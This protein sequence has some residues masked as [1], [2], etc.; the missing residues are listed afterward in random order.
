MKSLTNHWKNGF[1]WRKQEAELNMLPQFKT[2]IEVDGFGILDMHFV[3][4][5]SDSAG[6]IPLLFCHGCNFIFHLASKTVGDSREPCDVSLQIDD[7]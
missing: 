5:K 6:A 2:K 4:S 1:D 3:H 7:I